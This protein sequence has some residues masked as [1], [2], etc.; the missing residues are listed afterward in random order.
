MVG[1]A[2]SLVNG[3]VRN[4]DVQRSI[5]PVAP[6]KVCKVSKDEPASAGMVL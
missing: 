5:A 6:A 4:L 3:A 2:Y 1:H